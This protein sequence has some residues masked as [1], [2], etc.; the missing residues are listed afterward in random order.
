[1]AR[2]RVCGRGSRGVVGR[3][4]GTEAKLEVAKAAPEGAR[5]GW[6][7]WWHSTGEEEDG[8]PE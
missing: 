2:A 3:H 6:S 5:S 8:Q 1:V 7:A 4:R